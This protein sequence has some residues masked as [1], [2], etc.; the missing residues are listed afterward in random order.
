MK[1]CVMPPS[2]QIVYPS[3]VRDGAFVRYCVNWISSSNSV[4]AKNDV[5][6]ALTFILNDFFFCY[7]VIASLKEILL[8]LL[9]G[10]MKRIAGD[11]V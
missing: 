1:T 2:E 4:G 5:D 9:M 7:A 10:K 6:D 11:I 8:F 3:H